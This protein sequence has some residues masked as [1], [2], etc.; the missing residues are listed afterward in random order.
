[1]RCRRAPNQMVLGKSVA[2]SRA[3]DREVTAKGGVPANGP[4]VCAGMGSVRS[5]EAL[6]DCVIV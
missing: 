2:D 1:M 4:D 5:G 3:R 6:V